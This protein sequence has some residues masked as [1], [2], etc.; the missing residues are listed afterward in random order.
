MTLT[1]F[2]T[3]IRK[4]PFLMGVFA[5]VSLFF[6][7]FFLTGDVMAAGDDPFGTGSGVKVAAASDGDLKSSIV[8]MLNYFLGFIGIL[9]VAI[10]IYAGFRIIV[11]QGEEEELTKGR[12]MIVYAI[13]GVVI[14]FLSYTIVGFIGDPTTAED[15]GAGVTG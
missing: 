9:L 5:A 7:T 11:S 3:E 8:T 6:V 10:I 14:I 12:T 4:S 1:S 15:A 2:F 13:I